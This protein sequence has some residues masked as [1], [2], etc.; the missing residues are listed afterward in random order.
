MMRKTERTL[1]NISQA[2]DAVAGCSCS[3]LAA[4]VL[5]PIALLILCVVGSMVWDTIS[6][7][8]K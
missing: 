2:S 3:A 8:F 7:F 1:Q 6:G 4:M 5:L